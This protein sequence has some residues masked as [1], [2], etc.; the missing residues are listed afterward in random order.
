MKSAAAAFCALLSW[1]LAGPAVAQANLDA[2]ADPAG[3]R[4]AL[5]RFAALNAA[6]ALNGPEGRALFAGELEGSNRS[7]L[8][9]LPP[10]DRIVLLADGG[11]VARLPAEDERRPDLY[12]FLRRSEQGVWRLTAGRSL[13]LTGLLTEL[14]SALRQMA[15]RTE[16]EERTL[17]N[18][19][20]TLAS[21][22]SLRRWFADHR[23]EMERLRVLALA[24]ARTAQASHFVET[25]EATALIARLRLNALSISSDRIVRA[26]IGG[27]VDNEVGFLH[28]ADPALV[29]PIDPS[30]HIWIEPVG[31][32]WYLF[33]TT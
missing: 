30:D 15:V 31:E 4:A 1:C 10:P 23:A 12:I 2:N 32:G 22:A 7:T 13:A 24:S 26:S 28:A 19:E 11:A 5:E 16:E 21:D 3:V 9:P 8:G 27:L 29:P 17:G 33:K 18:V 14:R 25:A 6:S 20:L